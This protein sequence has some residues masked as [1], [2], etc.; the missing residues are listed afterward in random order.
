ME[1]VGDIWLLDHDDRGREIRTTVGKTPGVGRV[2]SATRLWGGHVE[3]G[4][5]GG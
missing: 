5:H 2:M 4:W 3:I 1:T